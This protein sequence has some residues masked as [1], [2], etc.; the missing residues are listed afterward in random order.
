MIGKDLP[1]RANT[2]FISSEMRASSAAMS[3]A[4]ALCFDIFSPPPGDSYVISQ[5]ERLSSKE[6][7]MAPRLVRIAVGLC[8]SDRVTW[9]ASR[10]EWI[11]ALSLLAIHT[12]W[13]LYRLRTSPRGNQASDFIH[14]ADRAAGCARRRG[15]TDRHN[16]TS[17][18]FQCV[19]RAQSDVR[20]RC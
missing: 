4:D 15:P 17:A 8:E 1:V 10:V 7:K 14:Q 6:T 16:V 12:P 9:V 19:A 11:D 20:L 3:P 18:T 2:F 13:D 5:V